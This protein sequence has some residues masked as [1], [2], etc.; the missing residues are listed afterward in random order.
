MRSSRTLFAAI[1]LASLLW[2]HAGTRAP[3][4]V[5]TSPQDAA[6]VK[7]ADKKTDVTKGGAAE[8][9][10]PPFNVVRDKAVEVRDD[11]A[12]ADALG[13]RP[14][15]IGSKIKDKDGTERDWAYYVCPNGET[16]KWVL[17]GPPES[18]LWA[19]PILD[20][21]RPLAPAAPGKQH[22]DGQPTTTDGKAKTDGKAAKKDEFEKGDVIKHVL[23]TRGMPVQTAGEA[24]LDGD[25]KIHINNSSGHYQ[26]NYASVES[27]AVPAFEKL[28]FEVVAYR[29]PSLGR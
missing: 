29:R 19:V 2:L 18:E 15:K 25:H 11:L 3:A 5:T 13:I 9:S 26:P 6:Q 27:Y 23:V 21:R 17:T 14:V 20:L 28:G 22:P 16:F 12:I 7:A 1:L 10:G 4:Q 24:R 8:R